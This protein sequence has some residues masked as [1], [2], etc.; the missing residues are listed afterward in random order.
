MSQMST[1]KQDTSIQHQNATVTGH[2]YITA[3]IMVVMTTDSL[4]PLIVYSTVQ[5]STTIKFKGMRLEV[6]TVMLLSGM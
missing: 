1:C 6:L 5:K 2:S 3:N 4:R